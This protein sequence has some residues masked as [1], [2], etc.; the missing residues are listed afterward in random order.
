[1]ILGCGIL[2]VFHF[3]IPYHPLWKKEIATVKIEDILSY[4]AKRRYGYQFRR[5]TYYLLS[6]HID[7]QQRYVIGDENDS[8]G[9][10]IDVL[11]S[12]GMIIKKP[13]SFINPKAV[14]ATLI[15]T[16]LWSRAFVFVLQNCLLAYCIT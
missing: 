8:L 7:G 15:M 14:M 10:K 12:Q 4:Q 1:M 6:V 2:L 11:Y 5:Y 13:D 3:F 16:V 9:E